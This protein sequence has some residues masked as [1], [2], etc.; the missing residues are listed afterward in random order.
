[1]VAAVCLGQTADTA[2]MRFVTDTLSSPAFAGRGYVHG[3]MQ[4]AADFI[5]G[6]LAGM[7]LTVKQQTF[8]MPVVS[9]PESIG[10][11]IGDT[12][13]LPGRDF[14]ISEI[15]KNR[16]VIGQFERLEHGDTLWFDKSNAVLLRQNDKLTW[17]VMHAPADAT[18]IELKR[19]VATLPEKYKLT[20]PYLVVADFPCQNIIAMVPGTKTSD[21]CFVLTAHYDHLGML[22]NALFAGAN[23]NAS[24]TAMLLAMARYFSKNPLPYPVYFIAFAAEEAGLLGSKYFVDNPMIKLKS[25]R[26]LFNLD[27]MGNGEEGITVINATEHQHAFHLLKNI[28]MQYNL[29]P[30]INSRG[31][32]ANSDHY[33]FGEAGVPSF[34]AYTQGPRKAYHDVDD[35]VETL[36]LCEAGDISTLL[37][38]FFE[39]LLQQ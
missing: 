38:K 7:G 36:S 8:T 24:G 29:L 26:F 4:R 1:M 9:F 30:A 10:L 37:I 27:L 18:L 23:D 3:G 21:S 32:A 39:A 6:E 20:V 15:G 13:L 11:S 17:R 34:F 25:I 12:K 31:K 5:A 19:G 16:E 2:Y 28:N 14:I 35:T 33:W 22:G